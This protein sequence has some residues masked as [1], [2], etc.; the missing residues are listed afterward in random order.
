MNMKSLTLIQH[1]TP[2]HIG[3]NVHTRSLGMVKDIKGHSEIKHR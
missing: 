2:I 1:S 3:S